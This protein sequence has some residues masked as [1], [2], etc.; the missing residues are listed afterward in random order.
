MNTGENG[1]VLS[2]FQE[3]LRKIRL[4][5]INKQ[6][7][8]Q[9]FIDEKVKE[10][11]KSV[12]RDNSNIAVRKKAVKGTDD[13]EIKKENLSVVD[14]VKKDYRIGVKKNT[15]K[16][17]VSSEKD[18][19]RKNVEV[20]KDS[21]K[22]EISN[23]L[24]EKE[25]NGNKKKK[26]YV[27]KKRV[28]GEVENKSSL[29][30]NVKKELA[31][32]IGSEIIL[33]IK[34]SFLEKIDELDVL[35]S[36]LF[37]LKDELDN[38]LQLKKVKEIKK[39][40]DDLIKQVN[41]LI[42]QYNLYN[43]NYYIDNVV[44]IDDN[45]IVDDIINYREMLDSF[46]D[47]KKFVKEY[48]ALDEFRKLYGSLKWVKGETEELVKANEEKIEKYDIR[49]KK[50][51]KVKLGVVKVKEIDKDCDYEIEKQN[52]YFA[53]LM[54]KVNKIDR[55]EY[56]TYKLKGLNDLMGMSLRYIGYM[57]ISPLSGLIPSIGVNTMAT[58]RMIGNIYRNMKFEKVEHVYYEAVN[59]DSELNQHLCDVNYVDAMLDD[60]LKDVSKLKEEFMMIYD[61]SLPGYADT[62][63]NIMK[64]EE[65]VIHNQ[66]KV[67]IVRKKLKASK[68]LNENKL[69]RVRRLN[70]N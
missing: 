50:Y 13:T 66:N 15:L 7:M 14:N 16:V 63:K 31:N 34:S 47:E 39:K 29:K 33:K 17:G 57:M 52:K 32:D 20:D 5:R 43:K 18:L 46:Q 70:G 12:G 8:N 59:Y 61:S 60:T 37:F 1:G 58:R 2:K 19:P 42:E 10:I 56:S 40:I 54:E 21:L 6:K 25:F 22:E 23:K 51:D 4:S 30:D 3:R 35:E 67:D 26:G 48:K 65:K 28:I 64:I 24:S 38:E 9:E 49:D 53:S 36:E 69:V 68:K 44:G 62:L 55:H 41:E 45:V 11:R 27:Y